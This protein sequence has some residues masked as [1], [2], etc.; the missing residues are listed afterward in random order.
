MKFERKY[1]S[2]HSEVLFYAISFLQKWMELP[3]LKPTKDHL[4]VEKII[5]NWMKNPDIMEL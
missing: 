1:P 5:S 3:L 2:H 4:R